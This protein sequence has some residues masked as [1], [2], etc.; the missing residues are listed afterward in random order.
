M[1]IYAVGA[2][3]WVSQDRE[4]RTGGLFLPFVLLDLGGG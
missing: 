2:V 3:D 4:C 1:N